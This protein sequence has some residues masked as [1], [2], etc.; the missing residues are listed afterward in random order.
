MNSFFSQKEEGSARLYAS[1]HSA[2]HKACRV[3][4]Q[5][6]GAYLRRGQL[7][8][9]ALPARATHITPTARPQHA[10]ITAQRIRTELRVEAY[11]CASEDGERDS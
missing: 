5:E 1:L 11:A 4:V 6:E 8:L 2:L 3:G 10:H 9:D 7:R